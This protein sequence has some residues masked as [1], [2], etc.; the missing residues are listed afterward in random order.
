MKRHGRYIAVNRIELIMQ[1]AARKV[2]LGG[3]KMGEG[4]ILGLTK[5]VATYL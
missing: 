4:L 2:E 3:R 1:H 5:G